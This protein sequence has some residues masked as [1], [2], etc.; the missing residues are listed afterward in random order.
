MSTVAWNPG[1]RGEQLVQVFRV[2]DQAWGRGE[3]PDADDLSRRYPE[4]TNEIQE[5]LLNPDRKAAVV[6]LSQA[7]STGQ[8][9]G[10]YELLDRLGKGGEGTVF[11][12]RH[13]VT[14]QI[15]AL[16]LVFAD[17]DAA[18]RI[19][20][21]SRALAG[22]RHHHIVPVFFFGE[23]RGVCYYT[24]PVMDGGSLGDL[25]ADCRDDPRTAAELVAQVAGGVHHAHSRGILHLDLKPANVLLD[26]TGRPHVSDFGL[27]RRVQEGVE[28]RAGDLDLLSAG[29][30]PGA[31]LTH[32]QIRG[33]APYMSPEMASGE[34]TVVTTAA[35]VYGLGA[36]LYTLLT[37]RPPFPRETYGETLRAV[38]WDKLVP[39]GELNQKVDLELD[40]VCRKALHKNPARRYGSADALA[41]DLSRWLRGEPV[42]AARPTL[43]KH[44]RFWF[45]RHPWQVAAVMSLVMLLWLTAEAGTIAAL[46]AANRREARR[47]AREVQT[48]LRMLQYEVEDVAKDAEL[49][50]R[51]RAFPEDSLDQR[52]DLREFLIGVSKTCAQRFG[53]T[54]GNPLVN[55]LL[56]NTKGVI[57]ADSAENSAS[58]GLPFPQRDYFR[59]VMNPSRPLPKSATS[60][61]R[62]FRSVVDGRY[63]IG[64]SSR[65]WDGDECLGLF[66]ANVTLG[67]RLVLL[68]MTEEPEGAVVVSPIDWS[69]APPG[70]P[71]PSRRPPYLAAFHQSYAKTELEPIWPDRS[72]FTRLDDFERDPLLKAEKVAFRHGGVTDYHRVG[73]TPLVV[74]MYQAYPRPAR[75]LFNARV[76]PF[77]LVSLGLLSPIVYRWR[78]VR[79]KTRASA[80]ATPG[81]SGTR[82]EPPAPPV[83]LASAEPTAAEATAHYP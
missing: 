34:A 61:S 15:V 68:E 50:R 14:E 39:P 79:R 82:L 24:M 77:A 52:A 21:E 65:V 71:S 69:Y 54:G 10:E 70:S 64:V 67:P 47:L 49:R 58:V 28:A 6:A 53:M 35:D 72:R 40:A 23:D 20:D 73:E 18:R 8:Q 81:N 11:L 3:S 7:P 63:K 76:A 1:E 51:W 22:L 16:K 13:R 59:S 17:E 30:A 83:P 5:Y 42:L 37:G 57:L 4:F 32:P 48:Q 41:N 74:L 80:S 78:R 75:W 38:L 27:A 26:E 62:A 25:L 31:R 19:K 66:V 29:S 55:V 9:L 44:L 2:I 33:T 36:I 43:A 60:V 56:M 12:A 46:H 45:R